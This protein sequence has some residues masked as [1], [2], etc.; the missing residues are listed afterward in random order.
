MRRQVGKRL[1][2]EHVPKITPKLWAGKTNIYI[3]KWDQPDI[4]FKLNWEE[5]GIFVF[6]ALLIAL[7]A[8][9]L[10]VLR[11]D[12]RDWVALNSN[13][14][15]YFKDKMAIQRDFMCM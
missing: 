2:R 14:K 9:C 4:W 15:H 11:R 6:L 1:P 10:V 12:R 8:P 5:P 3:I 13:H 7:Y